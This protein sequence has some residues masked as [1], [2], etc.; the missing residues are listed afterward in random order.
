M[1]LYSLIGIYLLVVGV[2]VGIFLY[3][4]PSGN[5]LFDRAYRIVCVHTPR[6]LKKALSKCCGERAPQA[7]DSCWIYVCYT[8]NPM[9]QVFYLLVIVGG[10]GTFA[11]YG[12][13]HIPNRLMGSIHKYIGFV[14]FTVCLAVWWTACKANPGK[15]TAENVEEL[16]KIY[17]CDDVIFMKADCKTCGLQKPARSKH[18]SLCNICVARFDHHC[19]WINN[20]VGVGNHRWFLLFLFTHLVICFYG[21]G[22][23]AT[24]IYVQIVDQQLFSAQFVDPVTKERFNATWTIVAQYMLAT[25]GL[26]VFVAIL[27]GVMGVVLMGFFFWHLNLVRSGTTTNE[28]S[29][30]SYVRW[31]LKQDEEGKARLK[32]LKN[33]YNQGLIGNFREVLFPIDVRSLGTKS[34]KAE[35]T[36]KQQ[37]KGRKAAKAKKH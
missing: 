20:C 29:K 4:K 12:Y 22:L 30:W 13:P 27:G 16:C 19:I 6:L 10:Y 14:V 17:E 3:G 24:I 26:V 35:N 5:S 8:S 9:V 1:N 25:Q 11:A 23:G 34:D 2:A 36:G 18:C 32:D 28:V 7:L 33:I 37:A 31:L 21:F 15:I